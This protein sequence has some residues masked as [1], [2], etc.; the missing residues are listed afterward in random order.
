ML[1]LSKAHLAIARENTL[2][3]DENAPEEYALLKKDILLRLNNLYDI[4]RPEVQLD[5]ETL[6]YM[7]DADP[8][9]RLNR[10]IDTYLPAVTRI[11]VDENMD[12][13][14]ENIHILLKAA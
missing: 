3:G 10:A 2:S 7:I 5:E 12:K 4:V 8:V 14:H 6:E 1:G 13:F 9:Q 11:P